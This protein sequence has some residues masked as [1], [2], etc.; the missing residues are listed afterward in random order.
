MLGQKCHKKKK[1]EQDK[2]GR[3]SVCMGGEGTVIKG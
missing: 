1:I 3:E 2:G